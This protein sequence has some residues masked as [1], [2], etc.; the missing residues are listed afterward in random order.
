[1]LLLVGIKKKLRALPLPPCG[2]G[3]RC[4]DPVDL[5]V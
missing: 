4:K 1:M 2:D 5:S 3:E